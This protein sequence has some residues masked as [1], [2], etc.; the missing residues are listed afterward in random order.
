M[1]QESFALQEA[2]AD[3]A[4]RMFALPTMLPFVQRRERSEVSMHVLCRYPSTDRPGSRSKVNASTRIVC[5]YLCNDKRLNLQAQARTAGPCAA[6]AL[7]QGPPHM[8]R[9]PR[10][11][12]LPHCKQDMK[13]KIGNGPSD[14]S[15]T[16][17]GLKFGKGTKPKQG[18]TRAR[19]DPPRTQA[20]VRRVIACGGRQKAVGHDHA[21]RW[22]SIVN[23]E[24][25]LGIVAVVIVSNTDPRHRAVC[26][27]DTARCIVPIIP[28]S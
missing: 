24:R 25:T 8:E 9:C 7:L 26:V 11:C 23:T 17:F 18:G 28:C 6:P 13:A 14:G 10:S 3:R 27:D 1:L 21:M 12:Y 15:R 5:N 19:K 22:H 16:A 4:S 20:Q 2:E